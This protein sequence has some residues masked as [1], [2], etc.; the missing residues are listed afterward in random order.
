MQT[1][2][3]PAALP[4]LFPGNDLG[5]LLV[6]GYG[7]SIADYRAIGELLHAQGY[8]VHGLR[9]AGHG[10]GQLALR[11][12]TINDWQRSVEQAVQKLRQSCSWVVLLGSSFGAVLCLDYVAR[13]SDITGLVVVNTALAYKGAGIF[14]GLV[15]RTLQLFSPD[16][17]KKGLSD[18]ERIYA[19]SIGSSVAW[20][21][22]GILSTA[23]FA[24]TQ[25][26]PALSTIHV[27]TLILCS[28]VDNV[29]TNTSSKQLVAT[30]GSSI[31]ELVVIPVSTHRPFRDPAA[32]QFMS[33]QIQNFVNT[34][35]A[36]S[37]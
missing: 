7:G 11:Q 12:S 18:S 36:R 19:A 6:H 3:L 10:Q 29:V 9:L 20:P 28:S 14:Q 23:R 1:T 37:D 34:K 26:I 35:L 27:P 2:I 31:K 15:L 16:Y 33:E 22:N 24:K 32:T 25:V 17:P 5:I 30:L 4:F 13:H 21:I 8:T